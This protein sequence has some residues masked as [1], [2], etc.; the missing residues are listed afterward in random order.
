[1]DPLQISRNEAIQK[2]QILSPR[3][4][5]II[6]LLACGYSYKEISDILSIARR[7]VRIHVFRACIRLD[8]DT[9]FQA[10]ILMARSRP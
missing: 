1:M 8:V 7:T 2:V 10:A 9:A 5:K 4:H 3:Q 6:L